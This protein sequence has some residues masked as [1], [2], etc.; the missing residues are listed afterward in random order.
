M[1]IRDHKP[2]GLLPVSDILANSSDVGAI[3]IALR[4]GEELFY[5]Y[6][7]GFG[8]GQQTGIELPGETRGLARPLNRWSK[9]SIGA[10]SMGQEIGITPVQLVAMVST[11]AN[12]GV[13]MAPRIVAATTEPQGTPQTVLFQPGTQHRVLSPLVAA[14]MRQMM[15]GVVLHGTGR[16]AILEG[17]SSAGKTGTAQKVDP[18]SHSYSRT[19]YVASFV[20]FAPVNNPAIVIAVILDSPRA[21][22]QGGQ[23]SA[24]V[25]QRI[26]Q[27][28]LAYLNIPHDVAL[29][30]NRQ[31]LMASRKVKAED[32][33]ESSPDHLGSAL[34]V[35]DSNPPEPQVPAG[36]LKPSPARAEER[37]EPA[38]LRE[39]V[40]AL[41]L[42]NL[43]PKPVAAAPSAQLPY[44]G[45]VVLEVEQGGIVVPSFIGKS[46]RAAIEAAQDSGLEL[47]AVGSGVAHYQS[48][49]AG[50][51]VSAGT[52]VIV[53]FER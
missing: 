37:V 27:Q 20:G 34:E 19:N 49:P 40:D 22:H 50:S 38:A 2:C 35:A 46:I 32:L 31:L 4:L 30:A 8:F 12:D 24:P 13:W 36:S 44:A 41:I 11:I 43:P 18:G 7:R 21:L 17:Y 53:R 5:K 1:R 48:P 29:P 3:K 39:P 28:V 51:H 23:V 10:I 15:Q 52:K 47:D 42:P 33:E 25:F 26:V 16:K 14:E 9:V 45:T 6:I